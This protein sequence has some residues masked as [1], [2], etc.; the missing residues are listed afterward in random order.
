MFSYPGPVHRGVSSRD[1]TKTELERRLRVG[2]VT[3]PPGGPATRPPALCPAALRAGRG[4]D[5]RAAEAA[6]IGVAKSPCPAR[7]NG[8]GAQNRRKRSA[9]RRFLRRCGESMPSQG[10]RAARWPLGR[11]RK[12]PR[13]P[14]LRFPSLGASTAD[15]MT[16]NP[17]PQRIRAAERWLLVEGLFENRI[18][19]ARA[20][21]HSVMP[22]LDP[23]IHDE[24]ATQ[25]DLT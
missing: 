6:W 14:A 19:D 13:F 12:P 7:K 11:P 5:R 15:G 17:A 22:G 21:A 10:V 25:R 9:G 24:S 23:G 16:A 4:A 1:I 3:P 20:A 18:D 8:A 2:F